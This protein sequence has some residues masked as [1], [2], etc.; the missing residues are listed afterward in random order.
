MGVLCFFLFF[1]FF[2]FLTSFIPASVMQFALILSPFR[3]MVRVDRVPRYRSRAV[4]ASAIAFQTRI[5][6]LPP[7]F[8]LLL[9]AFH[10]VT[11]YRKSWNES[12]SLSLVGP[13]KKLDSNVNFWPRWPQKACCS[14]P[15]MTERS[16]ARSTFGKEH[17][18]SV[19]EGKNSRKRANLP[20]LL[21]RPLRSL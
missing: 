8:S 9:L 7:P 12:L 17:Q 19:P 6:P 11:I 18:T 13:V 3:E 2:F 5:F 1:P 4:P 16:P 15:R 10:W 21:Y 14:Y 20:L